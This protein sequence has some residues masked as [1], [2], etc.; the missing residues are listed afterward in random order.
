MP[1]VRPIPSSLTLR[2]SVPSNALDR[3][4]SEATQDE[5]LTPDGRHAID[6][7]VNDLKLSQ[8]MQ[9]QFKNV[10][11]KPPTT[12]KETRSFSEKSFP[13]SKA[14][15]GR[16]GDYFKASKRDAAGTK[17]PPA[18]NGSAKKQYEKKLSHVPP[19]SSNTA[20][21][22]P[23]ANGPLEHN[24]IAWHNNA[25][26]RMVG[27]SIE[28]FKALEP[29]AFVENGKQEP[30][31]SQNQQSHQVMNQL[32]FTAPYKQLEKVHQPSIPSVNQPAFT[33]EIPRAHIN[34]DEYIATDEVSEEPAKLSHKKERQSLTGT[35]GPMEE[36]LDQRQRAEGALKDL[37]RRTS[38][39]NRALHA[40]STM[41]PGFDHI[42]AITME[43]EP[44]ITA[45]EHKK[46]YSA[47]NKVILH[48]RFDKVPVDDLVQILRL[49]EA[50][51]RAASSLELQVNHEWDDGSAAAWVDQLPS[52]DAGLRA[53]RTA[54]QILTGG[55]ED[56][57]LYSESLIENGIKIF[58]KATEDVVTPVVELRNS[59]PT[60]SIFKLLVRNKKDI[61]M[62]FNSCQKLLAVL[63]DLVGKVQLA[64]MSLNTLEFVSSNLVFVDNAYYEKDSIVGVQKF[65]GIRTA[66]MDSLCQ[67]FLTKPEQRHGILNEIL[68]SLSKLPVTKQGSRQFK[69]TEGGNIQP[70]SALVMRLVQAS[71]V[72]QG[73]DRN[74]HRQDTPQRSDMEAD[75]DDELQTP[76][77]PA[78][79]FT[80]NSEDNGAQQP[81][82]AFD[83]LDAVLKPLEAGAFH[84]ATMVIGF[85]VQRA[86]VSTK[87]GDSPYRN[88]LDLCVEDFALCLSSQDWPAAELLLRCLMS[89]MNT[90]FEGEKTAAP[91]KSMALEVLG[92]LAATVSRLRSQVKKLSSST[93]T[94]GASD[95]SFYLSD[96]ATHCLDR[97]GRHGQVLAWTGPYRVVLEAI[98]KQSLQD[99][100][101]TGTTSFVTISWAGRLRNGYS[102][103]TDEH[104]DKEQEL[105][106][107]AYR[108]RM[109]IQD[110]GWLAS[111][112][113]FTLGT[114][115]DSKL[116]YAITLLG[117]PLCEA[118]DHMLNIL[119]RSMTNDQV[120]I[121]NRSLKS[122]S[123]VVETDPS[124][125]DGPLLVD[126]IIECANDASIQ[127]RESAL[128]LMGSCIQ[129]RPRSEP[130]FA[131]EITKRISDTAPSVRRRA[132]KLARDIYLRNKGAGLRSS[133]ASEFLRRV[134]SEPE[135]SVR[136]TARQMLEEV[137]FAPYYSMEDTPKFQA[138]L[139]DHT[140]VMI[141]TANGA[142][143]LETIFQT[144]LKAANPGLSGPFALCTKLV[145]NLFDF[146]NNPVSDDPN[147]PSG[148][149]ATSLLTTFAKSDPRLFT[150]EQ[151]RLLK[152]LLASK[153]T[154]DADDLIAFRGILAIL[155][156]V[157]PQLSSVHVGFITELKTLL[158][159][160]V[161]KISTPAALDDLLSCLRVILDLLKD[162]QPAIALTRS[163]LMGLG[164]MA[165][166]P[167]QQPSK[168]PAAAR[169]VEPS[170][171]K[172][173]I[174]YTSLLGRL[175]LHFDVESFQALKTEG[176]NSSVSRT[177]VDRLAPFA[178][179]DQLVEVRKAA[180]GCLAT[181][182][183]AW[184]RNYT[185]PKVWSLFQKAFM[186]RNPELELVILSS[187][188]EFLL[189]E[190][191]RSEAASMVSE[192]EKKKLTV[193]GGTSYDD[194]ASATTQR[195]L[196]DITRIS[197]SGHQNAF[198]ALQVLGSINRQGLTHPKEVGVTLIT[199]ETSPHHVIARMAHKEHKALHEKHESTL[200]REYA[201]AIQSAYEYQRDVCQDTRG[202]RLEPGEAKL[203]HLM[204]IL[205]ISKMKN[206]QRLFE[207]LSTL[208]QFDPFQFDATPDMPSQVDFTRFIMDNLAFIEYQTVG[209]LQT[210]VRKLEQL[211]TSTGAT[212]AQVID[213]EVFNNRIEETYDDQGQDQL[214]QQLSGEGTETEVPQL[215]HSVEPAR[216]RQLAAASVILLM[217]WGTR[218]YLRKLY[219]MGTSRSDSK[220]KALAKDQNR[221]P[222]KTQ[223]VHSDRYWD[224]I[225]PLPNSLQSRDDMIR[226]CKDLVELM[227]IDSEFKVGDE[228]DMDMDD[229]G[230]PSPN[231]DGED[232]EDG[233]LG[234]KRKSNSATP[235][236]RKKRARESSQLRKRGRPRKNPVVESSW[237]TAGD[238]DE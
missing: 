62:I 66:A 116:S 89:Q 194:V 99:A 226:K 16:V 235:S 177:M 94:S 231:E 112:F 142:D 179:Q 25:N 128:T 31:H 73:R 13:M 237:A 107:L 46:I 210:I 21:N 223:G 167:N 113:D 119:L 58:Q 193:M 24:S 130:D 135:E 155:R 115:T 41:E 147:V 203:H 64:D 192:G 126:R 173:F 196:P 76:Q 154:N 32:Q 68:T 204:D 4:N 103:A 80:V 5:G 12:S 48:R 45:E 19:S 207:K 108:L 171:S 38:N 138:A 104:E 148:Q 174:V 158:V 187:F 63:A 176:E 170:E 141:R 232:N 82:L 166:V 175:A 101:K 106:R 36:T 2:N 127:V 27:G 59:G 85:L 215:P 50:S 164:K 91:A 133:I 230:T 83:D 123:Q 202:A 162:M 149:D 18:T 60:S 33:I 161:G 229:P 43:Q 143:K 145:A 9:Y 191:K 156:N 120:S 184:P 110:Q 144:V 129:I 71:S 17:A 125:L 227:S 146:I 35:L 132:L 65:D 136:D 37:L 26:S 52:L 114:E 197:L 178:S 42:V 224:E 3:L 86:A 44:A 233:A 225:T 117:L 172:K 14:L 8:R 40:V 209:E 90:L 121:R 221:S 236:G 181:V 228:D 79:N 55:R 49:S 95:L 185:L 213:S 1:T 29:K 198:T 216:L 214:N 234:R 75:E 201:K 151:V 77:K 87:T 131:P 74:P 88:L 139:A 200:E 97:T 10:P 118:L 157:L 51:I 199:L 220:A 11:T 124:I 81:E 153:D 53:A 206:R 56:R 212:V 134:S 96:L 182:C 78:A 219:G 102:N 189:T 6:N 54:M 208:V 105:G 100:H 98:A 23:Q 163:V 92:V 67:I 34:R 39:I 218:T 188:K 150:F 217:I 28:P 20:P 238:S 169:I 180:I 61:A 30:S 211:V 72:S 47:I 140:A 70:V 15:F 57:Q 69:L 160:K 84:S 205:K 222:P 168:K 152:P 122:I 111:H 183:Q 186:E 93:D 137:W 195:F 159:P 109:M 165:Q 22:I 7:I 190:E